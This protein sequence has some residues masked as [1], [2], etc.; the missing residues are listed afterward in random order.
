MNLLDLPVRRPVAVGMV[1]L[2]MA[3][4]G[5]VGWQRIPV[6]LMPAIQG[7]SLYV[8]FGRSGSEPEMVEREILLPL[9]AR[10]S[11]LPNVAE[12]WGR[13]RGAGGNF[14]VRFE[15]GTDI[16]VRELELRRIAAAIQ[17]DQPRGLAWISV[18]ST[19]ERTSAFGS[20][21]MMVHV[22]G[23]ATDGIGS[24]DL[25]ALYDLTDQLLA[26][27]FAAVP[28]VSEAIATGGARRQVTVTVDPQRV[29]AAGVTP[30][31][32]VNAV[33]RNVQQAQHAGTLE[34]ENG[35]QDVLVEGRPPG[36]PA[37]NN[38]RIRPGS[39]ATLGHVA[40][41][42]LGVAPNQTYLRVNGEPAVG[43][44]IYQ[45]QGANL[46]R[47]GRALRE[48]MTELRAE[49]APLGL[50]L[51][52]GSDA[53]EVV[54]TQIGHLGRLAL[55][56][57]LIALVVLFLFLREWRAVA[58]VGVAVPVSLLAAIA[59]LYLF[60]QTLNVISLIGLS[61]SIG[62]LIDNSIV[63]YEAVL[64][65]LERG[66]SPA[67]AA[68]L[69]V[70]RTAL[71]IAAASLTTA[72]VFLPLTL[73]DLG[74]STAALF[75]IV[76]AALLLPLAA[77]LLVAVGLVPVL[78]Y[79]LAAPAAVHRVE[80]A[81]RR[82]E[83]S[84]GLRAPDPARIFFVGVLQNA[85]R[86]PS[87]WLAGTLF[88]V[89]ITFVTAVPL[90]FSGSGRADAERADE[91]RMV[92]R[93]ARG[94]ASAEALGV[95]VGRV[96]S[97]VMAL[98][99]V[100]TV[101]SEVAEE[102][103]SITVQFV[104]RDERPE[105]L[106]V[107]RV[108]E[109]AHDVAEEIEGF[110]LLRP[111]EEQRGGKGGGR[112][113]GP[114]QAF[115]PA[116][117]EVVLSGPET[118]PLNR[119]ARDVVARLE[120]VPNVENAWQATPPG[121]AE[122]WVEPNRRA[123]EAFGLTLDEVLPMLQVAGREGYNAGGGFVLASGREI[124]VMVERTGAREPF[125][126]RDLRRLRIHTA[127][128]VAPV[129]ALASIRQ[130]P[131]APQITHHNGRREAS[132]FFRLGRDVPDSG[133][134]LE[135]VEKEVAAVVQTAPRQPGYTVEVREEDERES[136]A[137]QLV[138]PALLL[139]VLVLAMAFES[140]TLPVLVLMA[141]PL[142][143]LGSAWLF[144]LTGTPASVMAGAGVVMLFGLAVNPAILLLD[145]IAQRVRGGWSAGAAALAAVRERTR[146]VLM[147]SAT[148][149]AALW[150]L[151]ITT[152]REN[153]MWPP[154]AIV[155]IGGLI[156]STVLT[157]LVIPVG[158]ILLQRL[159]R[160]FGRVGPWLVVGWFA[161]TLAVM[162]SLTLTNVI[163]SLLWQAVTS[164]LVGGGLLAVV[165]LLFRRA[166][167]A[168]PDT[169][170]G[171]PLVD[172]R[173]LRKTYGLPGPVRR[174]LR[175]GREFRSRVLAQ[176]GVVEG[177]GFELG[178]VP[179]RFGPALILSAAPFVIAHFIGSGGWT[180]VLWMLGALFFGR[181]LLDIRRARGRA[182]AAGEVLPGGPE[183][184]LRVFAPWAVLAAFVYWMLLAPYWAGEPLRTA[185]IL[186]ILAAVLLGVCQV[187]RRSAVRQQ[188]GVLEARV[189]FGPLKYP[190]TLLRRWARR[191]GGFDLP[192]R[193]VRAL[194]EVNFQVAKGMVGI[195]GP[196]GAG[197]TTLLRQLA[198]ILDPTRGA[199]F[200]GGVPLGKVRTVLA[201]WV[202]YLPQDAGLP[203]GLTARE[204][205]SY[206]AAL[207]DLPVAVRRERV[208]GLLREVG[209]GD[210]ADDKIKALSGGMRQRVAVARTLLRLPP[211]IIVDEPTVGLDPRERIR[212]R[213]LL[214]RLAENRIVLFSTH[215]VEDVAVAC[216]RVLVLAKG[217]LV[218]D[219]EPAALADAAAGRV[220]EVRSSAHEPF[221]LPEGAILAEEAPAAGV[222]V[223]R[224]LMET[225]PGENAKALPARLEDGYLW[226]IAHGAPEEGE[227]GQGASEAGGTGQGVP[228][229]PSPGVA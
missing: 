204:Y 175:A 80:R 54:Q 77:S 69:G 108:R 27:R 10:V 221:A 225:A 155:V 20:F 115:G 120:A 169:G 161:A 179:R 84:G 41:I 138:L 229:A 145:R 127:S 158:Y 174:A 198:G 139:L 107:S 33:R 70:R 217:R 164:L 50:D 45:E 81:R 129:A 4:L 9:Q 197:K 49:V 11:A 71:A 1:F 215:V 114:Q 42:G 90:A 176:G 211:V 157:L 28:G 153:E 92:A 187:V 91:M 128:G 102:G 21:V 105:D 12:T 40:D 223:R 199:I 24:A 58:V 201:R 122:M 222:T 34:S 6:E 149:I 61:L 135:A 31:E 30:M 23:R 137:R 220:W 87:A 210:K 126:V 167:T 15:S 37:F 46:I 142:A 186:P 64:R 44:V 56:G 93:Y 168:A 97:A 166:E 53:S 73:T 171:P 146:P 22:L 65:R 196:N 121:M 125:G 219:G 60:D 170:S 194:S 63:V 177:V 228:E 3:I 189:R 202:G 190:R 119:L 89:L 184:V 191:L 150:P 26:P 181:L 123:F 200:L 38:L 29:V 163:T 140:L 216:E 85:L 154:F 133:P 2:G 51:V 147:T 52:I 106:T 183:G 131:P 67:D 143:V 76:A 43:V 151:A 5:L 224:V 226:L 86:R 104:D 209:L 160:L 74:S 66:A 188:R 162:L 117:R 159:D 111:G 8:N 62:L 100:D 47:L 35:R 134:G 103:A 152:G 207:Y 101:V 72:I 78:A 227:A 113:G 36:L 116:P 96:E 182:N 99:G 109:V 98:A 156:T 193:P 75:G 172:V 16:K 192:V 14:Q 118:A 48:R 57:Y 82:R 132:V 213:N 112:E 205:L 19:E 218:F 18:S 68:R 94:T 25:E 208:E 185:L 7:D 148:T 55:S 32:V 144:V 110:E 206:F 141:L 214:G 203:G 83:R 180:L 39:P 95:A 124:P 212:F 173:N 195:L 13:V 165:V 136:L 88:A 17:R 59:L 178:E 130:M 79:R